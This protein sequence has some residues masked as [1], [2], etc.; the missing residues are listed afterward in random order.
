MVESRI[1]SYIHKYDVTVEKETKSNLA[2]E[3]VYSFV[4]LKDKAK[5]HRE[6]TLQFLNDELTVLYY[7]NSQFYDLISK[8]L[9]QSFADILEGNYVIEK[10]FLRQTPYIVTKSNNTE[11]ERI[12]R[13]F[14]FT[15][16]P[17]QWSLKQK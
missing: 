14:K 4:T 11:P 12:T 3:G 9:W 5:D 16:Q 1:S 15:P 2:G 13:E 7:Y 17:K 10:T 6:C 8:D